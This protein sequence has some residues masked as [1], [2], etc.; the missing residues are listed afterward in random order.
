MR[1]DCN[2]IVIRNLS[3]EATKKDLLLFT[4]SLG[5]VKNVRMPQKMTGQHR[6]YAFIEFLSNKEAQEGYKLLKNT[7][8]YGRKLVVEWAEE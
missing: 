3:F 1:T 5:D 6:G 7:H 2:K 8:F 4:K